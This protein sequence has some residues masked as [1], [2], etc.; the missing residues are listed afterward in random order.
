MNS[1]HFSLLGLAI[2]AWVYFVLRNRGDAVGW[3]IGFAHAVLAVLAI[4]GWSSARDT[5]FAVAMAVLAIYA[6]AMAASE[7]VTRLRATNV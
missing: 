6:A 5:G 2:V 3:W 7:I 1:V 4:G